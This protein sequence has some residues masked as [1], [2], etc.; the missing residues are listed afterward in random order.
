MAHELVIDR[1]GRAAFCFNHRNGNPWHRL[2]ESFDGPIPLEVALRAARADRMAYKA[3]LT[4]ITHG[5]VV[6]VDTHRAVV[7]PSLTEEGLF[8][9]LGVVSKDYHLVQYREV[10]ELAYAI[11]G[12]AG[13]Q[14]LI[15]TMG[16]LFDG[17]RFFGFIDFG[18]LELV[19]PNGAR[20]PHTR[21]LGFMSSHDGS[22]SI[23]FA[24]SRIRWVCNNTVTAGLAS[25]KEIVRVRHT[26]KADERLAQATSL[27][28][29]AWGGDEEFTQLATRLSTEDV[30]SWQLTYL[31]EQIWPKPKG[32]DATDRAKSIWQNRTEK[33][34]D[35]YEGSTCSEGFGQNRWS[36]YN[37]VSEYV[38]HVRGSDAD[39]R[40]RAAI[41]PVSSASVLKQRAAQ[42][43]LSV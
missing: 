23:T 31:I 38:D 4:S 27:L 32:Q 19:L 13:N 40:A 42:A 34:L 9:V 28:G 12:A 43:L 21:G 11:V 3:P 6:D 20:D 35:L 10:A 7:W 33:V 8:D 17:K 37:A 22:Q 5:G 18:D 1:A 14:A 24:N 41:D 36:L 29:L 39:R 2:G 16:L 25:A 26:A 30:L 15:D